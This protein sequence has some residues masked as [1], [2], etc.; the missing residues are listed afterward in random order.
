MKFRQ[1]KKIVG[2]CDK[3][4]GYYRFAPPWYRK[5]CNVYVRHKKKS[6]RQYYVSRHIIN[7]QG[8]IIL[9]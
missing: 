2:H 3:W 9:R 1:A 8:Q 7:E 6:H 5:V 4:R